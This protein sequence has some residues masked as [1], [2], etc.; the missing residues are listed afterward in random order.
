GRSIEAVRKVAKSA[1]HLAVEAKGR[2][3]LEDAVACG[4]A[5]VPYRL[6]WFE[7]PGN[8]LD[9]ELQARLANHYAG[10]MATGKNLFLLQDAR[11][12]IRYA[13]LRPDRDILQFGCA[14]S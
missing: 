9:S 2:V 10:P 14:L 3:D 11:N 6:G 12:L 13:Q 4:K 1:D 8:P 5:L 7:E